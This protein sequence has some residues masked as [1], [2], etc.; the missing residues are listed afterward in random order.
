MFFVDDDEAKGQ[1]A[2]RKDRAAGADD[3]ASPAIAQELEPIA[4]V[5]VRE[6]RVQDDHRLGDRRLHPSHQLRCER[7]LGHHQQR[8]LAL[9]E[10]RHQ[11]GEVD[12]GLA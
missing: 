9:G 1:G 3:D 10:A 2:G 4:S 6:P 8:G 11:R 12:L 5:A 7:D